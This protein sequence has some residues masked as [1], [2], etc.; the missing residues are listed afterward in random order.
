MFKNSIYL[1]RLLVIDFPPI[2]ISICFFVK[3]QV[4]FV[5]SFFNYNIRLSIVRIFEYVFVCN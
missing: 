2:R 3:G 4:K 5:I 1:S